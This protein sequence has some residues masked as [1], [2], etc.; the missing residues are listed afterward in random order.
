MKKGNEETSKNKG[1]NVETKFKAK[2]LTNYS[3]INPIAKFMDKMRFREIVEA[4]IGI[5]MHHNTEYSTGKIL[6]TIVLGILSGMNRIIK[7][8]NF[9]GDPLV[10]AILGIKERID[11]DTI[12]GRLKRFAMINCVGYMDVIEELGKKVHNKLQLQKDIID[13]DSTVK[14][15][16]GNQEG[17]GK[18]Y[19]PTH[20]GKKS[21][22]PLLAFL[23]STKECILA[24]LRPGD[25]YTSNNAAEFMKE[26]LGRLAEGIKELIVRADSGFFNEKLM[27]VLEETNRKVEYI[28]KVKLKNMQEIMLKKEWEDLPLECGIAMT[29]FYYQCHGWKK[30]RKFVAIRKKVRIRKEGLLFPITDYEYFCYVTN[31]EESPLYLHKFYGDRGES[32]NW[33]E[34]VKNQLFGGFIL[35]D[36]FWANEALFL[37]SV[38]AYNISLWMRIL[39]DKKA[40]HEEPITFRLW[41]IQV[42]GKMVNSGRRIFLNMSQSFYYREK[43]EE[44]YNSVCLL[45]F[46]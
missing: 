3:G 34:A 9:S 36:D 40:W 12:I 7:I 38:L 10:R 23:N 46:D 11:K 26:L 29:E 28:I 30:A 25:S 17:T 35:T 15:V 45:S 2:E 33:I 20:R 1:R 13:L 27:Q 31:I 5:K 39:T 14:T 18:G 44:I 4:K 21:Y 8:E 19:N 42:A 37:S 41:F 24:Y 16:Y 22:H 43:W 6:M 32:E